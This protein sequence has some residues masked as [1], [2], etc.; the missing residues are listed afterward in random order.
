LAADRKK[1]GIMKKTGKKEI[2]E[3]KAV[4]NLKAIEANSYTKEIQKWKKAVVHLECAT[5]STT[6]D[7]QIEQWRKLGREFEEKQITAQQYAEQISAGLRDIRSRGTAILIKH[8]SRNYLLTARHVLYDKLSAENNLKSMIVRR[9]DNSLLESYVETLE[10][11]IYPII[12]QVPSL[13]TYLKRDMS[14]PGECLMALGAGGADAY[15]FSQEYDLAIISLQ[16][17]RCRHFASMLASEGYDPIKSEDIADQ[18]S[19][20]GAFVFSVGYPGPMSTLGEY[21]LAPA[22]KLW[23]SSGVSLPVFVFGQIAMLHDQL[24]DFYCDF[25]NY[26]GNSGAPVIENNLM[27]GLVTHQPS[28]DAHVIQK[29]TRKISGFI[30]EVRVAFAFAVKAR[31]IKDLVMIQ[32]EKDDHRQLL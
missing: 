16:D 17:S 13:D 15:T 5:D 7:Q 14:R 1:D 2:I 25:T 11:T 3:K 21:K 26:Q 18:P 12:F 30:S 20:E 28:Y 6:L 19:S 22:L 9:Y 31:Y 29:K 10:Q 24:P 8:D 23:S 27:V 32:V 4:G